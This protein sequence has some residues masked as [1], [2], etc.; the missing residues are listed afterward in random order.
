MAQYVT[1]SI[2][3]KFDKGPE[4]KTEAKVEVGSYAGRIE[5]L[6]CKCSKDKM[7][8]LPTIQPSDVEMII[9]SADKYKSD[10]DCQMNAP[11]SAAAPAK[12]IH[13]KFIGSDSS[14]K[15]VEESHTL[16]KPLVFATPPHAWTG[17][18]FDNE[19]T[20]DVKVSFLA[21]LKNS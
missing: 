17:I 4:L 10:K 18:V 1:Y 19:L 5:E 16:T 2:V 12:H 11:G 21:V 15:A 3:A 7:F 20:E 13:F 14:G 6:L 8:K 9:V